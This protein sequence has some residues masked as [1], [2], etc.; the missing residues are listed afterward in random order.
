MLN[1]ADHA[2][3]TLRKARIHVMSKIIRRLP[4]GNVEIGNLGSIR[5]RAT[6]IYCLLE[7]NAPIVGV[8]SP[9][10]FVFVPKKCDIE[11]GCCLIKSL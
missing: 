7:I 9:Y 11:K 10:T 1:L 8:I 6:L 2:M 3:E 4:F 5:G